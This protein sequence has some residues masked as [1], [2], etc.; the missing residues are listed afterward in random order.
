MDIPISVLRNRFLKS[1]SNRSIMFHVVV[2]ILVLP[3]VSQLILGSLSIGGRLKVPYSL[4][5]RINCVC[6]IALLF[7]GPKLV[8]I[9]AKIEHVS[10]IMPRTTFFMLSI[11][12]FV[13][14]LS[15]IACQLIWK[16]AHKRALK[17]KS[18]ADRT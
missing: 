2:I 6:Q 3:T 5:T 1:T 16:K 12:L 13:L 11:F 10:H 14:F 8:D 17:E 18:F 4:L 7:A 9:E 15:V